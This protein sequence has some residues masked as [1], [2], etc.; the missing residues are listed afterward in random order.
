MIIEVT[1]V[2]IGST[3]AANSFRLERAAESEMIEM[4]SVNVP[5]GERLTGTGTSVVI[6][7]SGL[8]REHPALENVRGVARSFS[9]SDPWEDSVGHGTEM[10]SVLLARE[11]FDVEAGM[12]PDVSLYVGQIIDSKGTADEEAIVAALEW[13][14]SLQADVV[15]I[16]CGRLA[17][18]EVVGQ[19]LD[20]IVESGGLVFA[21]VGNPFAGQTGPLFPASHSGVVSVGCSAYVSTY[22]R[23][24]TRPDVVV[25]GHAVRLCSG[26]GR[27]KTRGGTSVATMIAAGHACLFVQ[28][29]RHMGRQDVTR[30]LFIRS[31]GAAG[32]RSL[33][34]V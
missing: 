4:W 18:S 21:P 26:D 31:L 6:L 8:S 34:E 15:A 19:A 20:Q 3:G 9:E 27:T 24:K 13:A 33:S 17:G 12:C 29:V 25:P 22:Q 11:G 1:A 32:V 5:W 28:N 23:W 16:P 2:I 7:D 14:T 30:S 10:A